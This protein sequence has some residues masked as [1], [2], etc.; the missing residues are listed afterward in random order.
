MRI[1]K[2]KWFARWSSS[3]D[4]TDTALAEAA[5]EIVRGLVDASLGGQ[6]FKKRVAS[7][8][9][10]KSSSTRTVVAFRQGDRAIFM[11]GFAKKGR[12]N[13]SEKE[14]KALKLLARELLSYTKPALEK[15]IKAGELIEVDGDG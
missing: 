6:V 9:R 8:G 1:F 12:A 15:A 10:G 4:L 14:L 2:T 5:A 13:I 11:Y 3:Q 7:R